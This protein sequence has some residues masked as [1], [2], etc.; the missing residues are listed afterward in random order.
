MLTD[1]FPDGV[2]SPYTKRTTASAPIVPGLQTKRTAWD[3]SAIFR[4]SNGLP[5]RMTVTIWEVRSATASKNFCC[6]SGRSRNALLAASPDCASCSPSTST[7]VSSG[8]ISSSVA[9]CFPLFTHISGISL[10]CSPLS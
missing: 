4:I 1:S 9:Y 8:S 7:T 2:S 3:F 10:S 6:P 5:D